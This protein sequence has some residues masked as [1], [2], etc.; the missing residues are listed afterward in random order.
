MEL[1]VIMKLI[2]IHQ[3]QMPNP[4]SGKEGPHEDHMVVTGES[5]SVEGAWE[6]HGHQVEQDPAICPGS[7]GGQQHPGLQQQQCSEELEGSDYSHVLST[8]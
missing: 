1:S 7:K 3:R 4:V 8:C 5:S 2:E 6:A